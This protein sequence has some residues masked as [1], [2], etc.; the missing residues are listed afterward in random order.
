MH[1]SKPLCTHL[2]KSYTAH[3][4]D[5]AWNQ[6]SFPTLLCDASL[7]EHH[8]S[9]CKPGMVIT[10]Y[11]ILSTRERESFDVK[12]GND[13]GSEN[14]KHHQSHSSRFLHAAMLL[15]HSLVYRRRGWGSSLIPVLTFLLW[16]EFSLH[17]RRC[18]FND[19]HPRMPSLS[20]AFLCGL[21]HMLN[22]IIIFT[23]L[24]KVVGDFMQ[25]HRL[26]F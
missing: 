22:R 5:R 18:N 16:T 3:H 24:T 11:T 4:T 23:Y 14:L 1:K 15:N 13:H 10:Y 8:G 21:R 7:I 25:Q 2:W 20:L 6:V 19:L 9:R 26:A 17:L 12:Q